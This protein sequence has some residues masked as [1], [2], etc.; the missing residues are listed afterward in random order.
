MISARA[1]EIKDIEPIDDI[2]QRQSQFGVPS[3]KHVV[4]NRVFE[5]DSKVVGY[6]VVKHFSEGVLLIDPDISE[7]DKAQ[8]VR[9]ALREMILEA[10]DAGLE[11][12]Y[13]ISNLGSFS[14][15]LRKQ[16]GFKAVPGELLMLDL[17]EEDE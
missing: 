6:G 17:T 14:Q 15:I 4:A 11:T 13:V 3:L 1:F 10:R 16:C 7:R 2:F 9:V 8:V 5:L 12:L